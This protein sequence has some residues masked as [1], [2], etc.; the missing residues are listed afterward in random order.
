M[1][2]NMNQKEKSSSTTQSLGKMKPN[3][4]LSGKK[5]GQ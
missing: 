5:Y 1:K 3:W 2:L 4:K